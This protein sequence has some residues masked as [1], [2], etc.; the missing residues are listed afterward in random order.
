MKC[1]FWI[2]L[3]LLLPGC[4]LRVNAPTD[5]E[6]AAVAALE[7]RFS[8]ATYLDFEDRRIVMRVRGA[9]E[10][11]VRR[12]IKVLEK[13][14]QRRLTTN[15]TVFEIEVGVKMV[16]SHVAEIAIFTSDA[17]ALLGGYLVVYQMKKRNER[18]IM[19][20][21]VKEVSS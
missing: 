8:G 18:W 14:S 11:A 15:D 9:D 7:V 12:G 19:E 21:I 13:A 17:G 2:A 1:A 20:R 4:T 10:D 3:C 5:A 6:A 16:A